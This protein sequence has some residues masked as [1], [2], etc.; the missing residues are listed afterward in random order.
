MMNGKGKL[1]LSDGVIYEGTIYIY[2][3]RG[4]LK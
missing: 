3:L 4:L 2:Y 1:F